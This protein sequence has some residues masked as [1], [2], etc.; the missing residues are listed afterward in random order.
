MKVAADAVANIF[1]DDAETV[2]TRMANDRIAD[3]RDAAVGLEVVDGEPEA[4]E[5]TLHHAAGQVRWHA[6]DERLARIAVPAVNDAREIDVD[7]VA[8]FED[9]VARNAMANDIVDARA[10]TRR[11]CAR[12]PVIAK[13]GR[14]VAV[15]ARVCFHK[16]I[17]LPGCHAGADQAS[18]LVHEL[19]IEAARL[20]HALA[21]SGS[22]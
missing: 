17:D 10:A 15:I 22:Q 2:L 19:G 20:A 16:L 13:L 4:L 11:K 12:L 8:L 9:V 6:D 7:D 1:L 3:V 21:L 18:G 5:R 14:D